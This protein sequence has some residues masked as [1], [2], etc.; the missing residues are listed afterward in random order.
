M[1]DVG[2]DENTPT[3]ALV[4]RRSKDH[5]ECLCVCV[6][7]CVCYPNFPESRYYFHNWKKELRKRI[8]K[9]YLKL[10]CPTIRK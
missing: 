1:K 4:L 6:C 5:S 7:V 10:G 3:P 2:L 9:V 8:R